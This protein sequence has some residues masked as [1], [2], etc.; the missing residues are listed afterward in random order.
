MIRTNKISIAESPPDSELEYLS[1]LFE[2]TYVEYDKNSFR[3]FSI[4]KKNGSKAE[5]YQ[6]FVNLHKLFQQIPVLDHKTFIQAQFHYNNCPINPWQLLNGLSLVRYYN[7]M[8]LDTSRNKQ[9]KDYEFVLVSNHRW[10]CDF[11]NSYNMQPT[12]QNL[13]AQ[14]DR[15]GNLAFVFEYDFNKVP[16]QFVLANS[17]SYDVVKNTLLKYCS[18]TKNTIKTLP[19]IFTIDKQLQDSKKVYLQFP[20]LV[21]KFKELFGEQESAI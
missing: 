16:D 3:K 21:T 17:R 12:L 15:N 5:F 19:E 7:F 18:Q 11:C 9:E 8:D 1:S 6:H 2:R 13:F 4:R 10:L 14:R 20:K